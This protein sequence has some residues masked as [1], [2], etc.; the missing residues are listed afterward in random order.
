MFVA[1]VDPFTFGEPITKDGIPTPFFA[2]QWQNLI[3]LSS[4]VGDGVAAINGIPVQVDGSAI[5]GS[6]L[7][8]YVAANEDWEYKSPSAVFDTVG[9]ARGSLLTRGAAAWAALTPGTAGYFLASGGAGA[10]LA[11]APPTA[12]KVLGTTTNDNAAAGYVGEEIKS[13]VVVGSGVGLTTATAAN[14][15]SLSLTAGDWEVSINARFIGAAT[16]VVDRVIASISLS[17]ATLDSAEGRR[18]DV[19]GGH[20]TSTLYSSLHAIAADRVS[21]AAPAAVYFIAFAD[22]TISTLAASGV[23]RARRV[24]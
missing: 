3:A 18:T 11:W 19:F 23:I 5:S 13:T 10:D 20:A 2:R 6:A 22:F 1:K 17:S 8:Q 4:V 12:T 24:R 16:T 7:L 14:V 21:L 15:T 9:S